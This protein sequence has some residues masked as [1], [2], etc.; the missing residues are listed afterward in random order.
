MHAGLC[1]RLLHMHLLCHIPRPA[2]WNCIRKPYSANASRISIRPY[3]CIVTDRGS[4]VA[5]YLRTRLRTQRDNLTPVGKLQ[6]SWPHD[7]APLSSGA[8]NIHNRCLNTRRTPRLH[9]Q[10]VILRPVVVLAALPPPSTVDRSTASHGRTPQLPSL[11]AANP[12]FTAS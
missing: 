4:Q 3:N 12:K 1:V 2:R 8:G 9:F 5:K 10:Q 7:R 11:C 6:T